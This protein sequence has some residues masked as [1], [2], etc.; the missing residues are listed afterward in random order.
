MVDVAC[1]GERT[2]SRQGMARVGYQRYWY[3]PDWP[4]DY[5]APGQ[6]LNRVV[7]EDTAMSASVGGE[8]RV[9]KEIVPHR[10]LGAGQCRAA[11]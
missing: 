9:S 2:E 8:A 6:P 4:Y 11:L 10:G 3:G 7:N 1:D 5:A